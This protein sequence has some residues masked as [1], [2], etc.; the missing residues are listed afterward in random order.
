M[1]AQGHAV[2]LGPV[3]ERLQRDVSAGQFEELA[4]TV[5]EIEVEVKRM[6]G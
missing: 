6:G 4:T 3:L 5:S 2:K 1:L